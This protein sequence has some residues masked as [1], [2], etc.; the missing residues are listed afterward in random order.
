MDAAIQGRLYEVEAWLAAGRS[1]TI[2]K[3]VRKTPLKVA[4][5]TGFHSLVELLLRHELRQR[6]EDDALRHALF[7]NRFEFVELVVEHGA[8]IGAIPFLDVL[9]TATVRSSPHFWKRVLTRLRI[10]RSHAPSISSAPKPRSGRTWIAGGAGPTSRN[11]SNNR[12]TW[13]C[14]SS[15]RR[16]T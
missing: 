7:L 3:E 16:A 11:T 9:I 13:R 1:L 10:I 5:S 14:A 8:S 15:A 4:I 6:E 12:L 2:P